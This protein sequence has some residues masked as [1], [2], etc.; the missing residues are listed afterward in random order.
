MSSV[1]QLMKERDTH[2]YGVLCEWREQFGSMFQVAQLGFRPPYIIVSDPEVVKFIC[3]NDPAKFTKGRAFDNWEYFLGGSLVTLE[4]SQWARRRKAMHKAFQPVVLQHFV[5]NFQSKTE[6]LADQWSQKVNQSKEGGGYTRVAVDEA[7]CSLT[8]DIICSTGFGYDP[9]AVLGELSQF[10]DDLDKILISSHNRGFD[11]FWGF[12]PNQLWYD[13]S[14]GGR[15]HKSSVDAISVFIKDLIQQRLHE[16]QN[17]QEVEDSPEGIKKEKKDMLGMMVEAHLTEMREEDGGDSLDLNSPKL[18]DSLRRECLLFLFAGHETT[19]STL[20]FALYHLAKHPDIANKV[21]AEIREFGP[22]SDDE[23]WTMRQLNDLTYTGAVIK[24]SLRLYP[25]APAF[26]RSS[27]EEME[28]GG[29][30][31][32]AETPFLI[33]SYVMHRDPKLW[34]NPEEFRPERFLEKDA[35]RSGLAWVPFASGARNCLGMAMALL[36][37]KMV[38]ASVIRR[39]EFSSPDFELKEKVINVLRPESMNL[40]MRLR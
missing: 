39:F 1:G 3:A 5:P 7:L 15:S 25:P 10:S 8:L 31:F 30:V 13:W 14:E 18:M 37:S 17:K 6:R 33:C 9:K 2:F 16:I 20:S 26:V 38:L 28:V 36:E 24:E 23:P 12:M 27:R 19:A 4:G 22:A 32:P 11:I 29:Y 35:S 21:L 40:E 34:P